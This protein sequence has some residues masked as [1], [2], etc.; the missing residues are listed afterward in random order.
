V[1]DLVHGSR[2]QPA[3]NLVLIPASAVFLAW[4]GRVLSARRIAWRSLVPFAVLGAALLA[5]SLIVAAVYVPHLFSA[6]ASRYG[7]IG[8]VLAMISALFA[9]MVV[10]VA[11]VAL[12]REVADELDRIAR[13][14]RPPP[15]E[16]KR[17][18]D[19]MIEQARSRWQTLRARIDHVRR[20]DEQR[21]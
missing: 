1:R 18:W 14:G 13:G 9:L 12:G 11:C 19:V 16:I 5:L 3:A 2:A 15:D 17:E 4:T 21:P 6:Y 7:V 8:A 20:R 10:L